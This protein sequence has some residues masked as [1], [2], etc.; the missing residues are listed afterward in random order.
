M[1]VSQLLRCALLAAAALAAW[2][3]VAGANFS[4]NVAPADLELAPGETYTGYVTATNSGEEEVRLRA[5]LGDWRTTPDGMEYFA[6]GEFP[7]GAATW[8]KLSPSQLALP[9]GGSE[10]IYYEIAVPEDATLAG[11]YWAMIFVEDASA[12]PLAPP[13]G[14]EQ[15]QMAIRTLLRYGVQVFVT[16]PGTEIRGAVFTGTGLAPVEGGFD[17]SATIENRGN[18]HLRPTTWLELRSAAGDTVYSAE[19]MRLTVLPG[20]TREYKFELRHLTLP[21]GKYYA[22]VI[23]DYGAPTLVA[24]QAEL[25]VAGE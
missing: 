9:P 14:E 1:R 5:Y 16:I 4:V 15:P 3:L 24:A 21:P 7:R 18:I 23:A 2:S 17:L 11:S 20:C 10:R 25:E 12:Q 8:M 13:E 19:H 22:L 6:P